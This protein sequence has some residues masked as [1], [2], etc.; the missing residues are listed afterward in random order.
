MVA[1]AG[2]L[3]Q[4]VVAL[5]V[6]VDDPGVVGRAERAQD[7]LHQID[8]ARQRDRLLGDDLAERAPGHVLHHDVRRAAGQRPAIDHPDAVRAPH[9]ARIPR[10]VAQPA[11]LL[12]PVRQLGMQDLDR[13]HALQAWL[14]G[15]E[16]APHAAF[17]EP[18]AQHVPPLDHVTRFQAQLCSRLHERLMSKRRT[19]RSEML[20]RASPAVFLPPGAR[21]LRIHPLPAQHLRDPAGAC[22]PARTSGA[23]CIQTRRGH[24]LTPGCRAAVGRAARPA[25]GRLSG[26]TTA[27]RLGHPA[28]VTRRAS[29]ARASRSIFGG[30]GSAVQPEVGVRSAPVLRVRVSVVGHRIR[31]MVVPRFQVSPPCLLGTSACR[32]SSGSLEPP[33]HERNCAVISRSLIVH[34]MFHPRIVYFRAVG[35]TLPAIRSRRVHA[36]R[37]VPASSGHIAGLA[38][39]HRMLERS[40]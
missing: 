39:A 16:H 10:L 30:P 15:Q 6:A 17:A 12:G 35:R 7:L 28:K 27:G 22:L 14:V 38:Q 2:G 33:R 8:R 26:G 36:M 11:G 25:V 5:D 18:V 4:E 32:R 29:A 24:R 1:A 21:D 20:L 3:D 31:T 37:E 40:S 23:P 34:L 13:D 19:D 9:P